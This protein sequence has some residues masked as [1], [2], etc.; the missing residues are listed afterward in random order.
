MGGWNDPGETIIAGTGQLY[1][2]AVGTALP[3]AENTALNAAFNGLGYTTEEGVGVNQSAEVLRYKAWQSKFDV[4]RQRDSETFQ[5]TAQLEQWNEVTVPL[6]FGGGTIS[7]PTG[8]HYKYTPPDADDA[9]NYKAVI[10]DVVDG[11]TILRFVM[12][13]A[14]AVDGV[15]SQLNRQAMGL[16]PITLEAAEPDDGTP[17]WH[18]LTN[19]AAFA[20]G[21]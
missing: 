11:S 19:S 16:L 14:S 10:V 4:R 17:A 20:A 7:E 15:S 8:G 2:A 9:E 3:A 12:P 21:S 13:K 1:V 5:I 18:F 6:A